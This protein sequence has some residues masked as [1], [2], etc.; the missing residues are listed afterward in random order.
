[1]ELLQGEDLGDVVER[2]PLPIPLAIDYLLQACEAIAEAHALGI[3]HRD[4]KP[5]NLFVAQRIGGR[6][7]VKVL[8]FGI[9]KRID[10]QDRAL[11]ATTAVMGSPQYMSPE[12]MKA[13]RNVDFRTDIWSLGVCLYEL[14][15]GRVPW[16]SEAVPLLCAMVLKDPPPPLR[17]HRPDVPDELWR[18]IERCLAKEPIERI[19]NVAELAAEIEPFGAPEVWGAAQRI[20]AVLD[21]PPSSTASSPNDEPLRLRPD[22][23]LDTR[24]AATFDSAGQPRGGGIVLAAIAGVVAAL[25]ILGVVLGAIAWQRR[26]AGQQPLLVAQVTSANAIESGSRRPLVMVPAESY[27]TKAAS[28]ERTSTNNAGVATPPTPTPVAEPP[29]PARSPSDPYG[30]F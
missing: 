23:E 6:A 5:R 14:I 19:S 3:V 12:Q 20:A 24:T 9:A 7:V 18:V 28:A 25:G 29:K 10:M 27:P 21:A 17:E 1:M 2:G 4:L 15:A 11:T 30:K 16:D 13:S 8:D 26:S 22:T